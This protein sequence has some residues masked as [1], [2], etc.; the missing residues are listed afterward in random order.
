MIVPGNWRRPEIRTTLDR[1]L[2][3]SESAAPL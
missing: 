3:E 2:T 1:R